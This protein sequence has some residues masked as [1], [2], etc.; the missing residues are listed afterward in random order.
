MKYFLVILF[1]GFLS[2][3]FND[4][5]SSDQREINN[6]E[7]TEINKNGFR[8]AAVDL[9][10]GVN[11]S[12][13]AYIPPQCYTNVTQE[14]KKVSNPCYSCHVNGTRPNY[15]HDD[16]DLQIEYDFT[17]YSSFNRYSNLFKDRSE[18][19]S[20]IS[21]ELIDKYV[22][23]SNYFD[24]SGEIIL[25]EILKD[26]PK[27]WDVNQDGQWG[28]Y[29]PDAYFNFDLYGMDVDPQGLPTGWV[30]FAYYPM[31]GEFFPT[32]GSTDDVLIRLP[33]IFRQDSQSNYSKDVYRLNLAIIEAMIR[34]RDVAID[35]TDETLY[36]VDLDRNGVLSTATSVVYQWSPLNNIYMSYVGKAK[37]VYEYNLAEMA[38]GLYPKGTEFLHSVRYLAVD[39]SHVRMA[40]RMKELRYSQKITWNNYSQLSNSV[41]SE[42]KERDDFPERLSQYNSSK[43]HGMEKGLYNG[44][45]WIYQGFIESESGDLRPQTYEE[46][47]FCMGCHTGVGVTTDSSFAYPRKLGHESFRNGFYHW[48]EKGL[49]G[50]P[51]P[52]RNDGKGEYLT[53]LQLN[54]TGNEFGTNSEV[55]NKFYSNGEL[56]PEMV[57]KLNSD[58][59]ELIIP[60]PARARE[61]NK[62]YKVIVD[63]QSYIYG[64]TGH[65]LPIENIHRNIPIGEGTGISTAVSASRI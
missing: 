52:L 62:S 21:D 61:L 11:N 35:E 65:V 19:V 38:A 39:G 31:M 37:Q 59:S 60:S 5:S 25:S 51:D 57:E 42:V 49:S 13:S 26:V 8:I 47:L 33:N 28:G 10:S 15:L 44:R 1:S 20:V 34:E 24:L 56:I 54:P 55:K 3:C 46:T 6:D 4:Q 64:R 14:N 29:I 23:E 18:E 22:E 58:I 12:E 36:G 41:S 9:I 50:L 45:G 2:A 17:D 30:V 27:T 16:G 7:A 43:K 63:E 48:L 32:N 40:P 53:Y